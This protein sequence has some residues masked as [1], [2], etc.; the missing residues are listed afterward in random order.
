MLRLA[1]R[2]CGGGRHKKAAMHKIFEANKALLDW[3]ADQG[4]VWDTYEAEH[5]DGFGARIESYLK[6][7]RRSPARRNGK[8]RWR[9]AWRTINRDS[10]R[11]GPG[12]ASP[13]AM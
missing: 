8:P 4:L 2:N 11:P 7:R 6:T 5:G 13:H 10:G 9:F 3:G 12:R 1:L